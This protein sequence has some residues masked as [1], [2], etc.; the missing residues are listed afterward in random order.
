MRWRSSFSASHEFAKAPFVAQATRC[1]AVP[2]HCTSLG[3]LPY[4]AHYGDE[5]AG[6]AGQ[7][8]Q[9]PYGVR[10]FLTLPKVE[11]YA[12]G[13]TQAAGQDPRELGC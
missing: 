4:H 1:V 10:E 6:H 3:R 7:D 12:G 2:A 13:V 8:E 5:V 9:V 11:G